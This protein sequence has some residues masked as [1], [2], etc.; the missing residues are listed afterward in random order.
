M[1]GHEVVSQLRTDRP[2][3]RPAR[4]LKVACR[5]AF[6][7]RCG[8]CVVVENRGASYAENSRL[9]RCAL[10]FAESIFVYLER[11]VLAG[12]TIAS[13]EVTGDAIPAG[14]RQIP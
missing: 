11:G 9:T 4:S 12:I 10:P 3:I 5:T 14:E 7:G 13:N 2:L 1:H 6:V 8:G